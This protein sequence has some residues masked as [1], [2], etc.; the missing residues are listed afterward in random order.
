MHVVR[1][2]VD[3]SVAA[4]GGIP[5]MVGA[6]RGSLALPHDGASWS[7]ARRQTSDDQF[8]PVD[9][10]AG[11]P[12]I[13]E[14]VVGGAAKPYVRLADPKDLLV[15]NAPALEFALLQTSDGHQFL[16][17]RPKIFSNALRAS[18]S[19]GN[20]VVGVRNEIVRP[21]EQPYV[22]SHAAPPPS[23]SVATSSEGS[24]VS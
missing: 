4:P 8:E 1:V 21:Y 20:G 24:G 14:G 15:E 6:A 23:S 13:R 7:V 16:L 10:I 19:I 11:T 22:P 17:P 3:A 2:D 9:P 5:E 18:N 12:L